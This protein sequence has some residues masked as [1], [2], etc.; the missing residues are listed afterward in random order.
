MTERPKLEYCG[1][2]H[3]FRLVILESFL[4]LCSGHPNRIFSYNWFS[5]QISG[6]NQ[7]SS[8]NNSLLTHGNTLRNGLIRGRFRSKLNII[9]NFYAS[10]STEAELVTTAHSRSFIIDFLSLTKC[11]QLK[12]IPN[13]LKLSN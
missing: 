4:P 9:K 1:K 3:L 2:R 6:L 7:G 13:S 8:A 12:P 11:W 10:F 5:K